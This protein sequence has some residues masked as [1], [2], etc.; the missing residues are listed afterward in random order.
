MEGSSPQ[1]SRTIASVSAMPLVEAGGRAG[2]CRRSSQPRASTQKQ[3]R[4]FPLSTVET[5]FG[6]SGSLVRVSYQ[7]RKCPSYRSNRA[8]E[9]MVRVHRSRKSSAV[10]YPRSVAAR[11]DVSHNPMLVGDVLWATSTRSANWELS[12]GS[13][14]DSSLTRS[15]KYRHV[16]RAI[17]R[18][19]PVS[20]RSRWNSGAERL[21]HHIITGEAV[22]RIRNTKVGARALFP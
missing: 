22:H 7:L 2:A 8:S 3:A 4:R 19:N 6:W 1:A 18:R 14:F 21:S 13:Q 5:Y 9:S 10:M 12:G 15:S 17:R 16:R 11:A 20:G